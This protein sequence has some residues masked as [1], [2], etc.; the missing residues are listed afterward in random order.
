VKTY[1]FSSCFINE[2]EALRV[3]FI[4]VGATCADI[5]K[6]TIH[7]ES[8]YAFK[9]QRAPKNT[10]VAQ[11]MRDLRDAPLRPD[12]RAALADELINHRAVAPSRE[13]MNG[14]AEESS[15]WM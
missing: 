8:R 9:A 4:L 5:T 13:L 1:L 15:T 11:I 6:I 10:R 7:G 2:L 12:Q 3:S 14:L